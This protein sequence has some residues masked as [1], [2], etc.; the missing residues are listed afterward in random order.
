MKGKAIKADAGIEDA[1][2]VV[3]FVVPCDAVSDDEYMSRLLELKECAR[4]RGMH[5]DLILRKCKQMPLVHQNRC[6]FVT[7]PAG[8]K[9]LE[10]TC[11][12]PW[13]I[14]VH[15]VHLHPPSFLVG[16]T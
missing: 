15:H 13:Y 5:F 12:A 7:E 3:A 4:V 16:N 1:V 9:I 2:H 10:Y 6:M 11:S 14:A 8:R